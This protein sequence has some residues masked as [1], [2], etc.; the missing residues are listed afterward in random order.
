MTCFSLKYSSLLAF[1]ISLPPGPLLIS[2]SFICV[3][4]IAFLVICLSL[5][6]WWFLGV[7]FSTSFSTLDNLSHVFTVNWWIPNC[8][9]CLSL[10]SWFPYSH[11]QLPMDFVS[12]IFICTTYSMFKLY[13]LSFLSPPPHLLC[14][15]SVNGT[16]SHPS[17]K[18]N[19]LLP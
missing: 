6:T 19:T 1:V 7:F 4:F 16:T 14:I 17:T 15:L 13:S 8:Y 9:F 5:E 12:R 18:S 11:I 10:L 3:S 2:D